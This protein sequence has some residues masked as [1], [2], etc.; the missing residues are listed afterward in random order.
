MHP[1]ISAFDKERKACGMSL[2]DAH[3]LTGV[4][5]LGYKF[6]LYYDRCPQEWRI[7]GIEA[8]RLALTELRKAG[9]LPV[10]LANGK[11][12]TKARA[13]ITKQ[14]VRRLNDI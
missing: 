11:P 1:A 5:L 12:D 9:I 4:T 14:L 13:K 7:E 6:W 10:T 3:A 2:N 8:A